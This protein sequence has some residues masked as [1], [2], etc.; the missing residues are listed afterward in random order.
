MP[1]N[2]YTCTT[3]IWL[4]HNS[5]AYDWEPCYCALCDKTFNSLA[6][7]EKHISRSP[8]HPQCESC[9]RRFLNGNALR[10]HIK[11]SRDH[12]WVNQD[13]DNPADSLENFPE[14][15]RDDITWESFNAFDFDDVCYVTNGLPECIEKYVQRKDAE[16]VVEE[17]GNQTGP[18]AADFACPV[19]D[20]K[21]HTV[22]STLCGH[23]FCAPCIKMAFE[24]NGSCPVC[25]EEGSVH[26][27]RKAYISV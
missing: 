8:N 20:L 9:E 16:E 26:Q 15:T 27:L 13:L 19:C 4:D 24:I 17:E 3:A 14:K 5:A 18:P 10:A 2:D 12:H 6:L 23:L 21:P 22:C 25:D 11:Y 1:I 7:R